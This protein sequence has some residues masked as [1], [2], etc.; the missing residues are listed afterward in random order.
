MPDGAVFCI[1][2]RLFV[3]VAFPLL[4]S[5]PD[6]RW[7]SLFQ[8]TYY[9]AQLTISHRC[10]IAIARYR[11]FGAVP[12][13]VYLLKWML[14]CLIIYGRACVLISLLTLSDHSHGRRPLND[15]MNLALSDS[16]GVRFL[17]STVFGINVFQLWGI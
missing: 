16:F 15:S 9:L 14:L 8:R 11:L 3:A 12:L 2:H 10:L 6:L 7:I 17:S 13:H 5:V 1:L 4:N